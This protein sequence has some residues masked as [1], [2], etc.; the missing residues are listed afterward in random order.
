MNNYITIDQLPDTPI[1]PRVKDRTGQKQGKFTF[2]K[3]AEIVNKRT[4]WWAQC[5]CGCIEKIKIGS[6]R[7]ACLEC[8][9]KIK[10]EHLKGKKIK[11]LSNQR[12]GK[13]IALYPLEER[14]KDGGVFWFC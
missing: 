10:S 5:D 3:F 6:A 11:D 1:P 12:F 2:L 14:G 4:Y 7:I 13:L 8:S 9:K